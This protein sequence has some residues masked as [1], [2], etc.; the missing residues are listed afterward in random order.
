MKMRIINICW[1]I[2]LITIVIVASLQYRG[3]I[4]TYGSMDFSSSALGII[5]FWGPY[6]LLVFMDTLIWTI[7]R[8]NVKSK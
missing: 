3:F 2:I 1:F 7:L 6:A 4:K 5:V 8:K